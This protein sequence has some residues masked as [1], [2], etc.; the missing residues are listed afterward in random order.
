MFVKHCPVWVVYGGCLVKS[1]TEEHHWMKQKE[2]QS[3]A[4]INILIKLNSWIRIQFFLWLQ[5][6]TKNICNDFVRVLFINWWKQVYNFNRF[7]GIRWFDYVNSF[8]VIRVGFFT[9]QKY[10]KRGKG[11]TIRDYFMK[12][13]VYINWT[14]IRS[15]LEDQREGAEVNGFAET[16][17]HNGTLR[18][19][20]KM[21]ID[22]SHLAVDAF[23]IRHNTRQYSS[24][25]MKLR[26]DL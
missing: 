26:T 11:F 25:T 8:I 12:F 15:W 23:E 20:F 1:V 4:T 21:N 6:L 24:P 3:H 19:T 18:T 5:N 14:R 13:K 9:P 17:T 2:V 22:Y 7:K 16:A 10:E